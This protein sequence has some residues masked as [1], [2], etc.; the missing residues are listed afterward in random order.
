MNKEDLI[1]R[2]LE[3]ASEL[4]KN[5]IE[6]SKDGEN[7]LGDCSWMITDL[8]LLPSVLKEKEQTKE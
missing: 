8:S 3:K 4:E 1:K 2:I 6:L 7:T 5:L